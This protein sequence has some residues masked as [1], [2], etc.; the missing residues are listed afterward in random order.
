MESQRQTRPVRWSGIWNVFGVDILA[1]LTTLTITADALPHLAVEAL[2]IKMDIAFPRL[3]KLTI[4]LTDMVTLQILCH[5]PRL[6]FLCW[7]DV[8][9]KLI[10]GIGER[11]WKDDQRRGIPAVPP[12]DAFDGT[13][14]KFRRKVPVVAS[15]RV[16]QMGGWGQPPSAV[17]L[18]RTLPLVRRM[19]PNIERLE[20]CERGVPGYLNRREVSR[21]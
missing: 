18:K 14:I 17:S 5:T 3:V 20:G 7:P 10:E 12:E 4:P 19:F 9:Q 15:L 11:M 8:A 16:L 2:P 1:S 13:A 6:E 21:E